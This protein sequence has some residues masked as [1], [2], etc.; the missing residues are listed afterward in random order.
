[1]I[2]PWHIKKG[3]FGNIGLDD[4]N[5]VAFFHAPGSM[6]TG[7]KWKVAMYIDQRVS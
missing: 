2:P 1:V 4:L 7:P 3:N 5:V 6:L